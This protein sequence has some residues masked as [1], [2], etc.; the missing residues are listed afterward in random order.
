MCFDD[1]VYPTEIDPGK[2][3]V[4]G[5]EVR[6]KLN[7]SLDDIKVKWLKERTVTVIHK[8]AARFLPKNIKDD[9]ERTFEDG[10][11]IG[12]EDL[13]Q[14]QRRGRIKIEGLGVASYVAKAKEAV[15]YMISEQ[16]VDVTLGNTSYTILFKPWMTRAQF[17]ELRKQEEDGYSG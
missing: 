3:A 13:Q 4:E 6:F 9:L 10:W 17:R 5:R 16:L 12:N 1:G 14:N 7:T 11:I 2:M 8:D 15:K